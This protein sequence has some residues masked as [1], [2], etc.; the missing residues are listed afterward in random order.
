MALKV[1]MLRKKIDDAKKALDAL[2]AADEE[3]TKR[4]EELKTSIEEAETEEEKAA[5]EE[6]IETYEADKTEHDNKVSELEN[7]ISELEGELEK[8]EAEQN[9]DPVE[10][11]EQERKESKEMQ[12]RE[13]NINDVVQ[14]ED[15]KEFLS[16]VRDVFSNKRAI[17]N[18]GLAVPEVF[19]G[20][21]RQNIMEYSK[22]LKHVNLRRIK[23]TGREIIE[24]LIPEAI[25]SDCCSNANELNIGLY[26]AEV[27]CWAV[28]GY[29]APCR[30]TIED[31]DVNLG[32]EIVRVIGAAIGIAVDKAIV[33]GLGTRMPLGVLTS[34]A[35]TEA[36]ADYPETARPWVDLHTTNITKTDA[37]GLD[38]FQEIL[39]A[40]GSAK[41]K[42]SRGRMV[43]IMND[44]TYTYLKAQGLSV[45]A[46]GVIVSG[47]EGTMPVAGGVVEVLDF[48]ADYDIIFGYFD[49]YL[50]AERAG[51]TIEQ[52]DHAMFLNRRRVYLG[53]AR[54]DG[55]P[56]IREAFGAINVNNA[57]VTTE[58]T[59][60][61]DTANG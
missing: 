32:Q 35:Q 37:T 12:T 19:L 15:V 18:E 7:H 27:F 14:R 50:L 5:V 4:S 21:V 47:V 1:L 51:I 3:F 58:Y 22:L 42:Y 59:F 38:L 28:G 61:P 41:G 44:T 60:A 48:I 2:R 6:A 34:L 10:E 33:A 54:Y 36:P 23:G 53:T 55:K 30:S 56:T 9:T 29:I 8:E 17:E 52:S 57:D 24:G 20:Y 43:W 49:L 25:W 26:D 11:P 45:N 16:Q 46:A 39:L 40:S 13:M 31:S